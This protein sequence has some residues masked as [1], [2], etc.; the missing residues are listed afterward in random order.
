[1]HTSVF[2]KLLCISSCGV[3]MFLE[4]HHTVLTFRS[5]FDLLG[6][7][8]FHSKNLQI[9]SKLLLQIYKHQKQW[10]TYEKVFRP[11]TVYFSNLSPILFQ[12]YV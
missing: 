7:A 4:S 9:S 11:Y 5:W 8:L 1:M 6:V 12:E 2:E 10:K 3:V